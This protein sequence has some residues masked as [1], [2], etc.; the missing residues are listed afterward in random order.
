[1]PA[2]FQAFYCGTLFPEC[3]GIKAACARSEE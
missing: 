2:L 3:P 1:M